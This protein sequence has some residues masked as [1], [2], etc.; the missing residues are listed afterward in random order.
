MDYLSETDEQVAHLR[1]EVA[2]AEYAAKL[3]RKRVFILSEGT[4]AERDAFAECS[5]E[6]QKAE[7]RLADTME[8]YEKVKAK[9]QTEVLITEVWRSTEASRRVGNV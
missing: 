7:S 5:P 9:R 6:V 2:R 8:A 3:A 1:A 4:V